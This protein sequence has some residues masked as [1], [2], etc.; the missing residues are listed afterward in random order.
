MTSDEIVRVEQFKIE[1]FMVLGLGRYEAIRAVEYALDWHAVAA[2][3]NTGCT[4]DNALAA[5]R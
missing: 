2:L 5:A 4:L 3:L 1:R